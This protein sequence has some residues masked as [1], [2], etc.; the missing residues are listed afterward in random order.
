MKPTRPSL[1]VRC[2]ALLLLLTL[3]VGTS[4]ACRI[5]PPHWPPHPHPPFPPRPRPRPQPVFIPMETRLHKATIDIKK[6]VADV[7]VEATF[8]NPNPRRIEGTYIFPI[9]PKAAVSSFNM[10]I[11]GKTMEAELLD[12]GKARSIYEGI[13][14]Q[15]KDP[16]LLEY[17]DQGLLRAR[18]FPIEPHSEVK[19]RLSYECALDY[20]SGLSRFAYPLLS[21]RPGGNKPVR[22][23]QI[24]VKVRADS[25]VTSLFVPGFKVETKREG[26]TATA[27][28]EAKDFTPDKDFE[29]I[30][31]QA[32]RP[33]G[34][35]FMTY[36]KGDEGYFLMAIAPDSELQTQ[37]L[38]AKD[39]TFVVD[40]SGSMMGEKIRQAQAALKFCVQAL[41]KKDR[42]N[43]VSFSTDV[44]PFAA[45]PVL[46]DAKGR[47]KA[48]EF[49]DGLRAMGGTAIDAALEFTLKQ[50]TAE[51]RVSIVV[52]LTD[53][54]PTV[55][56]TDVKAI[57]ARAG[58]SAG[59]RRVFSF[60]VGY[61]VN[62]R[63]LDGL[64]GKT[65]GYASYVRPNEN[66][67]LALSGFYGK[68]AYPVLTDLKLDTD[69]V[70]LSRMHPNPLPDLF[71]GAEILVTG[72]VKTR[73]KHEMKLS[74]A[75]G[76]NRET[77][78][79]KTDLDG[80]MR[81]SFIPRMWA[82]SR[83]AYLQEQIALHGKNA[84]LVDEV[85]RL[86]REFGILT[87]FTS[88]LIVEEGVAQDRLREARRAFGAATKKAGEA[89]SGR[90]AVENSIRA[91][92][93]RHP[94]AMD[95]GMG[96]AMGGGMA[97]PA[98]AREMAEDKDFNAAFRVAGVRVQDVKDLVRQV[99]DKTFYYRRADG[100]WYDS[101]I[102]K[103]QSPRI[104][105]RVEAWSDEFFALLRKHPGLRRYA[106]LKAEVVLQLDGKTIRIVFPKGE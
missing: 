80:S 70:R 22:Q 39:I 76:K 81:N 9:G 52:F 1:S 45:S 5:I 54:L 74:G 59:A 40:T 20:D 16:A 15:L 106:M 23:V 34:V 103:G 96:G 97:A 33:V 29:I 18:V 77:F 99:D 8:Y 7:L 104:D 24:E 66:L 44:D 90:R 38:G 105:E 79:F 2:S 62:T 3:C 87:Q 101:L 73:G 92:K 48:L 82:A 14:R 60:G 43:I 56:E 57:L 91:S 94:A 53:G 55:G 84:E 46:A 61:D 47:E 37:E 86:G 28:F 12:A 102:V 72:T 32:K 58:K 17:M 50:P 75:V 41:N 88:F 11:N 25:A 4:L 63:L 51:D 100:I 21:A 13:V 10:T 83:V 67:E 68:I 35:D 19:V 71:K 98:V 31:G 65:R 69:G 36:R 26:K 93:A 64:S 42:F 49:V 27:R 30:F 6:H 85:K 95:G 78:Q 89:Q